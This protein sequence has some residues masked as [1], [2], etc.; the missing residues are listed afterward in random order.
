MF[1]RLSPLQ[2]A[3]F[4]VFL[5]F[6]GFA[7]FALTRD[8]YLR[9][10]V[11][12][13]AQ[14]QA[15]PHGIPPQPS[16]RLGERLR[17]AIGEAEAGPDPEALPDDPGLLAREADRAFAQRRFAD[18]IL[19]YRRLL[20]L[21]PADQEARNDLGLALHY[22]GDS[23]QGLEVL[24]RGAEEAPEFQRIWLSLGFVALQAGEPATA[25][26]ALAHAESLDP[27]SDVGAEARRLLGLL[28][29]PVGGG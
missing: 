26:Q 20:R 6:Y 17:A 23:A 29:E 1:P 22:S 16:A 13:P 15:G 7:V 2:W 24:R 4:I 10:P 21:D 8:Y 18:A 9:H 11:R 28:E 14:A 3:A 27:D 5:A 12:S 25:R 19:L